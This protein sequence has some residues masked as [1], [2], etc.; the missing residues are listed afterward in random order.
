MKILWT[1]GSAEPNPGDGGFAV[2]EVNN[3]EGK[4]VAR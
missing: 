4:P 3:N 2:I 1:D